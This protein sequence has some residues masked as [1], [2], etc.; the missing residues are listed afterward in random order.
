MQKSSAPPPPSPEVQDYRLVRRVAQVVALLV[1]GFKSPSYTLVRTMEVLD[2][3][4]PLHGLEPI[5][6]GAAMGEVN[7]LWSQNL[8]AFRDHC[9]WISKAVA[10]WLT[11]YAQLSSLFGHRV[12][13][14][15]RDGFLSRF[16]FYAMLDCGEDV[17]KY[18]TMYVFNSL[19]QQ[20]MP[21][22]PPLR[23][24]DM[25]GVIF[26][27]LA[28]IWGKRFSTKG[29]RP[30]ARQLRE[31][32]S[33]LKASKGCEP[34]SRQKQVKALVEH[35]QVLSIE[36][37]S[38]ALPATDI[39]RMVEVSKCVPRRKAT[40]SLPWLTPSYSSHYSWSRAAGG[41][42]G[43]IRAH[44]VPRLASD[45]LHRMV[46]YRS[47][48]CGWTLREVRCPPLWEWID[49]YS[50]AL[51]SLVNTPEERFRQCDVHRVLEPFKVRTITAGP[52]GRY[53]VGR[54]VNRL[55]HGPLGRHPDFEF[56]HK[57]VDADNFG[58]VLWGASYDDDIIVSGDYKSATDYIKPQYVELATR[59]VLDRLGFESFWSSVMQSLLV[60][61]CLNYPL[62]ESKRGW[63]ERAY[64]EMMDSSTLVEPVQV[65]GQL[66]G[67]PISFPVLNLINLFVLLDA[68]ARAGVSEQSIRRRFNGDDC[69][70]VMPHRLYPYWVESAAKVGF[71]LSVGKNYVSRDMAMINSRLY[72]VQYAPDCSGRLRA[73]GAVWCP[74]WNLGIANGRGRVLGDTRDLVGMSRQTSIGACGRKLVE[75]LPIQE[76]R[77][78]F[79]L[80]LRRNAHELFGRWGWF[81]PESL[82]GAGLPH[83]DPSF[84]YSQ[85]DRARCLL[86]MEGD[87]KMLRSLASQ[88]GM[89]ARPAYVS[90]AVPEGSRR[91]ATPEDLEL[92]ERER[93]VRSR[94]AQYYSLSVTAE[95][96]VPEPRQGLADYM[97]LPVIRRKNIGLEFLPTD[98]EIRSF[99]DRESVSTG[100]LVKLPEVRLRLVPGESVQFGALEEVVSVLEQA[101]P[102]PEPFVFEEIERMRAQVA[103]STRTRHG[104]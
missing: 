93:E 29:R 74:Y 97:V 55:I 40:T 20:D 46:Y 14:K 7:R 24:G 99:A 92:L 47:E 91:W 77:P 96:E 15:E 43:Y 73:T 1:Q 32:Y 35:S 9:D 44:V 62:L 56:T 95:F 5:D 61:H 83:F 82:G 19:T 72:R 25:P 3:Q 98:E 22:R 70:I 68:C 64:L 38:M 12:T 90:L 66:M 57:Q 41:A 48:E 84:V 45:V 49:D 79:D 51:P 71:R 8:F 63:Y 59:L 34:V 101:Q 88:T 65:S 94:L 36:P 85:L 2:R 26:P 86:A 37:A 81:V 80:F 27:G 28:R 75:G 6:V 104:R 60:G 31:A 102:D 39:R 58:D 103:R 42:A 100:L 50:V 11:T 69:L 17:L 21:S 53:S 33:V 4:L 16:I 52:P 76:S 54:I 23:F 67:S 78:L 13:E 89:S 87:P 10:S 18:H 30:T